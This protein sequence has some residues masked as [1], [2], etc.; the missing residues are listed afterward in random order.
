MSWY[1][2]DVLLFTTCLELKPETCKLLQIEIESLS[3]GK[4]KDQWNPRKVA[5]E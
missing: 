4:D 2:V 5:Y 3:F 1:N